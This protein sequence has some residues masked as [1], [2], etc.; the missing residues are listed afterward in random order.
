VL[1]QERPDK[2]EAM[3]DHMGRLPALPGDN[4]PAHSST[5]RSPSIWTSAGQIDRR[6]Q[7][8][9]Q[10]ILNRYER[11]GME[12]VAEQRQA[13]IEELAYWEREAALLHNK[14]MDL[15]R[16]HKESRIIADDAVE[17]AEFALLDDDYFFKMRNHG[18]R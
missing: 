8:E 4:S 12:A 1:I 9:H 7:A 16:A 17:A 3:S 10:L 6:E 2:E 18:Q 13:L 15:H 5:D 14:K 11:K